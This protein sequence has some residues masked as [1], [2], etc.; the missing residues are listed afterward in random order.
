LNL[1]EFNKHDEGLIMDLIWWVR[2]FS[3]AKGESPFPQEHLDF[4]VKIRDVILSRD[5]GE[6][7]G[8]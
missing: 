8:V 4:L 2:G 1:T 6:D 7:D 3:A 5:K